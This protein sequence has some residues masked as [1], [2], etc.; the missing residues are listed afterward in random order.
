VLFRS[1][2]AIAGA[3]PHKGG[4]RWEIRLGRRVD[5][6]DRRPQG[7]KAT[8]RIDPRSRSR[9]SPRFWAPFAQNEETREPFGREDR[10]VAAKPRPR[11][12]LTSRLTRDFA[13]WPRSA[14]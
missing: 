12:A 13:R 2:V 11:R 3:S 10:E 7:G 4:A 14:R 6:P 8:Q 5:A 9:G 1:Q